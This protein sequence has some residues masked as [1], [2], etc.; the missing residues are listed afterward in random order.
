LTVCAETLTDSAKLSAKEITSLN[1]R[2]LYLL[3][4]SFYVTL[5]RLAD[6]I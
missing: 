1:P 4:Q 5:H 3:R 2:I 6:A